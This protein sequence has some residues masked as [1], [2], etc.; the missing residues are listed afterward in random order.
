MKTHLVSWTSSVSKQDQI[1]VE[2]NTFCCYSYNYVS[3]HK[4]KITLCKV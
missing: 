3:Y 1:T 2:Y 4:Y